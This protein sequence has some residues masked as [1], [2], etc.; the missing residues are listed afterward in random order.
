MQ[1]S[2]S[3]AAVLIGVPVELLQEADISPFDVLQMYVSRGCVIVEKAE[4]ECPH[5]RCPLRCAGV[6][7]D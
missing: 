1:K 7:D 2:N 3:H 4:D 6:D 5:C